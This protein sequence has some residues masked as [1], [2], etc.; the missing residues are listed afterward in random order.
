[1]IRN[2]DIIRAGIFFVGFNAFMRKELKLC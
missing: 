1:M 2:K